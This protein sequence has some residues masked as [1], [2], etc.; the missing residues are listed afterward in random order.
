MPACSCTRAP[1]KWQE[2]GPSLHQLSLEEA[3]ALQKQQA[4]MHARQQAALAQR[5]Q[6]QQ[7]QQQRAAEME[8]ARAAAAAQPLLAQ[9]QPQA[10]Q[11]PVVQQQPLG[12]PAAERTV[13]A[14]PPLPEPPLAGQPPEQQPPAQQQEPQPQQ[15]QQQGKQPQG[16]QQGKKRGR[17]GEGDAEPAPGRRQ[18]RPRRASRLAAILREEEEEGSGSGSDDGGHSRDASRKESGSAAGGG[19]ARPA[20]PSAG[21]GDYQPDEDTLAAAEEAELALERQRKQG[22]KGRGHHAKAPRRGA[23]EAAAAA[24]GLSSPSATLGRRQ[25]SGPR[26]GLS[27]FQQQPALP[28]LL[29]PATQPALLHVRNG[30][31]MPSLPVMASTSGPGMGGGL[32]PTPGLAL[33]GQAPLGAAA[34]MPGLPLGGVGVP[35]AP[36]GPPLEAGGQASQLQL[37]G[38]AIVHY[39]RELGIGEHKIQ[40]FLSCPP[41]E[42]VKLYRTL[43]QLVRQARARQQQQLQAVL[44][45]QA[46]TPPAPPGLAGLPGGLGLGPAPLAPPQLAPPAGMPPLPPMPLPSLAEMAEQPAPGGQYAS[47]FSEMFD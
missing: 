2:W 22:H 13:V 20:G 43:H 11:P 42:Q 9:A 27:A 35:L 34:L 38:A 25:A 6:A 10:V 7:A 29:P 28:G 45:Q 44:A 23:K 41:E 16:K 36:A 5:V 30:G 3:R 14:V 19:R 12:G 33:P 26:T 21:S 18:L 37:V 31:G 24:G 32:V 8:R 39:A 17:G 47:L 1:D 40:S 46:A 15:P 4:A